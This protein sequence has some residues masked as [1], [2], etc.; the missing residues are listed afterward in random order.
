[1]LQAV[2]GGRPPPGVITPITVTNSPSKTGENRPALG[3]GAFLGLSIPDAA[4]KLL[5]T[6]HQQ[7]RTADILAELERGGLVLKSADKLNTVGSILLRRFNTQGDIVRVARGIWGL[8]E[9]YPGRKFGPA[10]AKTDEAPKEDE[11]EQ[12]VTEAEGSANESDTPPSVKVS[13]APAGWWTKPPPE[14][15]D[16]A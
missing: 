12:G 3:P 6:K 8:Q 5:E 7:M 1:M 9:W 13:G 4:K 2:R 16:E 14:R 15:A 10:K 11:A